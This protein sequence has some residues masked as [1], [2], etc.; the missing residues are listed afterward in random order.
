MVQ[1]E[2]LIMSKTEAYM[3][4]L[5]RI[6]SDEDDEEKLEE[7]ARKL[8]IKKT[9]KTENGYLLIDPLEEKGD[10][11]YF[12]E[13]IKNPLSGKREKPE[14]YCTFDKM[15]KIGKRGTQYGIWYVSDT[16]TF[17]KQAEF[18][19][20][21]TDNEVEWMPF[22]AY[23]PA[24]DKMSDGQLRTY[25]SWRTKCR[26]GEICNISPAYV[27]CYIYELLNGIG[28]N[29]PEDTMQKMISLW[30]S[31]REFANTLDGYMCRWLRDYYIINN[32][33]ISTPFS[34]YRDSFPISY[35]SFDVELFNKMMTFEWK[36]LKAVEMFSSFKIT[37]G[38]FYR[39][40]NKKII[41]EC[42]CFVL[43]EVS[44]YFKNE[45]TDLRKLFSAKR[46]EA[47]HSFYSGAI[48]APIHFYETKV[49]LDEIQT[50]KYNGNTYK[51]EYLDVSKYRAVVGYILKLIEVNIRKHFGHKKTLQPP[52]I[53][54]VEKSF[55]DNVRGYGYYS[56]VD[57][58]NLSIW[59]RKMLEAMYDD[60]FEDIIERAVVNYIKQANIII[61]NGKIEIVKPVEIDMNK[62]EKIERDHIETAKKLILEEELEEVKQ[63]SA[64]ISVKTQEGGDDKNEHSIPVRENEGI[65]EIEEIIR[66]LSG[67]AKTLL[68][69]IVSGDNTCINTEFLEEE[70]NEKALKVMGDNLI[71]HVEEVP[72]VFDYYIE[73]IREAK[74]HLEGK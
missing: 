57:I 39:S 49:E 53:K 55:F 17:I 20:N 69:N 3:K 4:F 28:T 31:C 1:K 47:I 34:E 24:Y 6:L 43:K 45:G 61:K 15:R 48:H 68:F 56:D 40:G 52:A 27:F 7:N 64:N 42:S 72:Q 21:F 10:G 29:N 46:R 11:R 38:Q 60:R 25:F 73:E 5:K 70:I 41:E 65:S 12:S 67:E 58:S 26:K 59:K 8:A 2:E 33:E 50:F 16:D 74:K 14:P 54:P 19:E 66:L 30:T 9:Q 32:K 63:I 51:L 23:Y 22:E 37:D 62:L 13:K 44:N 18:M 35:Y 36:S 71:E